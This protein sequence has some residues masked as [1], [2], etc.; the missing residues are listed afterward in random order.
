MRRVVFSHPLDK[1]SY[2]RVRDEWAKITT[3]FKKIIPWE[4]NIESVQEIECEVSN[5]NSMKDIYL[6]MWLNQK[7]Y[8]ETYREVW[9]IE[10]EIEFMID[11]W[12]WLYPFI[13][14]EWSSKEIVQKYTELLGFN[15][16]EGIFGAVDQIYLK[17]L[18]IPC[19]ILNEQTPIITFDNPPK[20]YM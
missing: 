10:D 6:A 3:T 12:P 14:I 4:L 16:I 5:F 7:A 2:L 8:Q 17:E 9:Q 1:N 15:Y 19:D 13:E 20:N 18:G 11:E